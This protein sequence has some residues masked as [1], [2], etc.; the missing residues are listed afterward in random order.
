MGYLERDLVKGKIGAG[1][2][3]TFVERRF[4]YFFGGKTCPRATLPV[5]YGRAPFFGDLENWVLLGVIDDWRQ[6]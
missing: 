5:L 2:I 3:E 1:R 6:R 4:R